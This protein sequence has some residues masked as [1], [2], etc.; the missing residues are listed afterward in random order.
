MNMILFSITGIS[1]YGIWINQ[2]EA[3]ESIQ[4]RESLYVYSSSPSTDSIYFASEIFSQADV[5]KF[6]FTKSAIFSVS[7][8]GF[9][10]C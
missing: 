4:A 8:A 3:T 2:T 6:M 5:G 1:V 10:F 7:T 9:L